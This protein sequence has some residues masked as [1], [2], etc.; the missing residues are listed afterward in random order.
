MELQA[1]SR[2]KASSRH[3]FSAEPIGPAWASAS[4]SADGVS[5]R[6]MVGFMVAICLVRDASLPSTCREF[7]FPLSRLFSSRSSVR[8]KAEAKLL[9]LLRHDDRLLVVDPN[10]YFVVHGTSFSR[11]L[12][13]R[14][15]TRRASIPKDGSLRV[16]PILIG[17]TVRP[18]FRNSGSTMAP[19]TLNVSADSASCSSSSTNRPLKFEAT[20]CGAA[21]SSFRTRA[22]TQVVDFLLY[23]LR[24]VRSGTVSP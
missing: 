22:A 20:V 7:Q 3:L 2:E 13:Q 11:V 9:C 14:P 10:A 21:T 1:E 6:T 15:S 16:P 5:K 19:G 23:S 12:L 18:S 8:R 17:M 4:R 24:L